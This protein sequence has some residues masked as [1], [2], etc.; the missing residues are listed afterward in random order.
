MATELPIPSGPTIKEIVDLAFSAVGS[1]DIMFGNTEN[2]YADAVNSLNAMMSEYPFDQLGYVVEDAAGVR[3]EEESGIARAYQVAVAYSLAER[4]A[5]GMGVSMSAR[6]LKTKNN[7]YS[8][9]CA[10]VATI[11]EA[12]YSPGTPRG[13][14]HRHAVRSSPF[15]PER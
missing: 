14:G 3:L 15:F 2:E 12:E 1:S 5:P 9:L 7:A 4:M 13:I 8:R 6:A 11:P 10:A